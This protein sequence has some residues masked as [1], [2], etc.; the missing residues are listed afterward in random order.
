MTK[1][2]RSV[3]SIIIVFG[4][5][6]TVVQPVLAS[7]YDDLQKN[8]EEQSRLK[9]LLDETISKEN[10][11]KSQ[12]TTMNNQ[13]KLTELKID[14]AKNRIESSKKQIESLGIDINVLTKRLEVLSVSIET[15]S[16]VSAQRVKAVHQANFIPKFLL[17]LDPEGLDKALNRYVYLDEV[18][19][20]D[21]KLLKEIKTR[22]E[23]Y[24][25]KKQLLT[26]KKAEVE[27]LKIA[28]EKE[29]QNLEARNIELESQKK[30]KQNLLNITKNDEDNYRRLLDAAKR[31]QAQVQK[32]LS[33]AL[34][35]Q[36][37]KNVKRGEII[38]TQGNT[39]YSTGS[40]L[41]FA[42]FHK[43]YD[44]NSDHVDPCSSYIVCTPNSLDP[45]SLSSGK[46]KLPL[47]DPIVSQ[48]YGMTWWAKAGAYGGKPH[49]G[50]DM[51]MEDGTPII[52]AEDGEAFFY[53]GGQSDGNGVFI[54]H[55]DGMMTLY[56]HL[57]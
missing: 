31:E 57:K 36:Q 34:K 56:W 39:G 50:I 37:R 28:V 24:K 1:F 2:V 48:G 55:S 40:H 20:Q 41:H 7:L 22:Q 26:E 27:S 12:I 30:D 5:L 29:K 32:A 38:G 53:R 49:T 23:D 33:A 10:S 4:I 52:A 51:Y 15:V 25:E 8:L 16:T 18:R 19:K 9:K 14:E 46:Y 21:I 17:L 11:L 42:V 3:F 43:P 6:L 35:S 54:Y 13:I 45:V 47:P 44:L